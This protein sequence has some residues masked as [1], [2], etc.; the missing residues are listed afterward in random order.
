MNTAPPDAL[1]RATPNPEHTTTIPSVDDGT[2]PIAEY[3]VLGDGQSCALVSRRGSVDWL[4]LPHFDSPASFAALLG[5]PEHGRWLLTVPDAHTVE[6]RYVG[7]SFVLETTYTS[8]SGVARI[9]DAMPVCD[10]RADLVRR[11]EVLSGT[12]T[13]EHEWIVRFGYGAL[14]PWVHRVDGTGDTGGSPGIR[15]IAGPDSMLLRGD[16]LPVASDHR[17]RD[18]FSASA[19]EVISLSCTW[20][21]SWTPPP[22][23][24]SIADRITETVRWWEDWS[25]HCG[26]NGRYRDA[27]V[28]SLLVLRLLTSSTTGGIV[29]AATTSLPEDFGG[30]RNWDYRFC[31][32][33][34]AA[35]TLEALI[36]SGY[37]TESASWQNW[38][39][40]AV[41]GSPEDLQIMY[42]VD[43]SR[44][45]P[46]R[47]LDH[48]P[49]YAGSRPVRIGNGA[50]HQVQNDVLGEV[51]SALEM[52]REAGM[53][54]D[55][56]SWALQRVLVDD[57]ITHWD[58][59]DRGIWEVR[60]P[61]RDFV[62]SRVMSW[63][64]LDRAVRA[65]EIHGHDGP[66][67]RW[68]AVK[69][70]IRDQVLDRGW[71]PDLGTFVQYYGATHTDAALLQMA[72]VGFID[73][74]D[75]RFVSTVRTIQQALSDDS[76]F[77]RRYSTTDSDDGLEGHEA[78]FLVCTFWLV[79]ALARMGEIEEATTLM[80]TAVASANDVGLMAEQ[81]DTHHE[82]M[83]GN[84][85]QAFSHLGLVRA[86]H[87]IDRAVRS[88]AA[89]AASAAAQENR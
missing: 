74:T 45:L 89:S 83:A 87:S 62:H 36:E 23:H 70:T 43:G 1:A 22:A 68:R 51:M 17:H 33:R 20:S 53:P 29:A 50:V 21:A 72:Q 80:D 88:R 16:R 59:P 82:R 4:C 44:D 31:W 15:A 27:L 40:R 65:V 54:H 81:Y 79:D 86:V 34:D 6:R 66:V 39:L 57:L 37:R 69:D 47:E 46:E 55:H 64:A 14:V 60:G 48:L 26:Y 41:A 67:E 85:P 10:G 13:I 32:L 75:E 5:T 30:G 71:D 11:V 12:V 8:A 61:E 3:A 24:L 73:P 76:G 52:T 35:M 63:A 56:D 2:T 25:G 19:G 77:V 38:L 42:S 78:P 49:G 58:T 84:F 18:V 7:D 28:R 9:I